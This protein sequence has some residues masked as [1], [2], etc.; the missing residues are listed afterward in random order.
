M[1]LSSLS[2]LVSSLR[3]VL[4]RTR[5]NAGFSWHSGISA[6]G[7]VPVFSYVPLDPYR[8]IRRLDRWADFNLYILYVRRSMISVWYGW[9]RGAREG[10]ALVSEPFPPVYF[11]GRGGRDD[12]DDVLRACV[13][14]NISEW[15]SELTRCTTKSAHADTETETDREDRGGH[16]RVFLFILRNDS[17]VHESSASSERVNF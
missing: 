17:S 3:H 8:G 13:V 11:V 5:K 2:P 15:K 9:R 7:A 16:V 6:R 14:R 10:R 4:H 12:S 1:S